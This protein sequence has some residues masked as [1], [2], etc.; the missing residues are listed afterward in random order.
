MTQHHDSKHHDSKHHEHDHPSDHESHRTHKKRPFH[1]DWRVWT[2]VI[3][4][5]AAMLAY[6]LSMDESIQPGGKRSPE[7]PAAP[8]R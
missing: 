7:M 4:M 5:L 6:V 3:L 8:A 1:Q 2:A